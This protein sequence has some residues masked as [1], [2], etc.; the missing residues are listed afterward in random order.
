M[1]AAWAETYNTQENPMLILEQRHLR[2]LLPET[3]GK[4]ILDVGCGTGRWVELLS[5]FGDAASLQGLDSSREMLKIASEKCADDVLL[6]YAELPNLPISSRSV[7]LVIASFVLSY[8]ED[9]ELCASE[10][11]RCVQDGGDLFLS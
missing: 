6:T 2:S 11:A 3:K 9:L 1:F 5:R 8:V 7:D 10:L 4:R